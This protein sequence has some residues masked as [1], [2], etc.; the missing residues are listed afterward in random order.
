MIE[1]R[2]MSERPY[3]LIAELTYRCPLRC[4]YCSNPT[5]LAAQAAEL[6]TAEWCR[7]FEEAEALGVM[8]LHFT[9]GEPL[10][11]KDLAEL[12]RH[13]RSLDLYSNL[14]TSGV[15][16]ARDRLHALALAGLD[17]VQLSVQD[18]DAE[19]SDRTAGYPSFAQKMEVAGWVKEEKL[20]L[21]VNVVLHRQ[22]LDHVAEIV[23][24]GERLRADRLELANT[25][26]LGWA[27]ENREA[28]LPSRAQLERAR[29]VADEARQ[30][31]RGA[32]EVVFVTPDYYS[33]WP[34]PCMDGWARR[35]LQ[36]APDGSVIP[37]HQAHT[38]P[39]IVFESV[40]DRPL[41]A[42]W[43]D[44]PSMNL[45]RGEDWMADPCRSCSRR[46]IDFG[47][48]RCQAFYLTGDAAA[49]DP[50]CSLS[51]AHGL[52]EAA[53]LVAESAA[54]EAEPRYLYRGPPATRGAGGSAPSRAR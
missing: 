50:A 31:L 48:C 51:P 40:R 9:G 53:R 22:N 19:R 54:P 24:L 4:P 23:A 45:F 43:N 38:L 52:I 42:I 29:A 17:N 32:M 47:G 5:E 25:Q 15:P 35:F 33:Q 16:L 41:A 44:S 21:T 20:P 26:Y 11:R 46:T 10:A 34:R 49:V 36:V 30:R 8:Q 12:V 14:I 6:T 2:P 1:P 28:L 27:L 7:V 3:T 37:C 39:G 18:V 13:A